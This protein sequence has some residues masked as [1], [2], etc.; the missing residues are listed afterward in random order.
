MERLTRDLD[1]LYRYLCYDGF[2]FKHAFFDLPRRTDG[3]APLDRLEGYARCAAYQGV[4]RALWFFHMDDTPGLVARL[5]GLGDM[6]EHAAAGLG[7]A[8]VFTFPDELQA[9]FASL[10]A[11]PAEFRPGLSLGMCFGLKARATT[12][13]GRFTLQVQSL[14]APRAEAISASIDACDFFEEQVRRDG[15]LDGYRRWREAV[16]AWLESNVVFPMAAFEPS[17]STRPPHSAAAAV[18]SDHD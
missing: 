12:D 6:G 18:E 14:P 8:A 11:L 10:A 15:A 5:R 9:S 13:R 17:S 7:L 2:G 4:G 3:L 1:P 16:T